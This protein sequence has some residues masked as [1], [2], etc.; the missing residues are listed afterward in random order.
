MITC[1]L[2][3]DP[4]SS[5]STDV[6]QRFT[7]QIRDTETGL[8]FFNAQYYTAS[9]GRFNSVDPGNAGAEPG[10]PQSWNGYAYVRGNPL[11]LTDPSGLTRLAVVASS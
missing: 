3:R 6:E 9:M 8:D 5:L 10:D 11:A 2:R 1:R 4:G 7:A